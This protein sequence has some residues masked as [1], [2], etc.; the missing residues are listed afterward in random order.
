M[1]TE[2]LVADL[3]SQSIIALDCEGVRLGRYGKLSLMQIALGED[4]NT[5]VLVDGIHGPTIKAL[6]PILG[7]KTVV[8]VMH[9][10]R[11]DSA[12]LFS[13]F[14][15]RLHSVADTQIANL[16]L[17]RESRRVLR[18]EAYSDLLSRYLGRS[19]SLSTDM[20][21]RMLDDPF[22]WHR[23]PLTKELVDYALHG[24]V[25]LIPLLQ[26]MEADLNAGGLSLKHV[27][28]ASQRWIEYSQLNLEIG[29]N[30]SQVEKIG[31]PLLGM[32]AAINDKGVY[33]KLNLARVG[34]CCTPSAM[35]RM[36]KGSGGF[37]PVQV[38]DTVELSVSGVS[39]D[40]KVLYV[41][42]RDP[43]WEYFD[44][45]RRPNPKKVGTAS[46]EYRHV[47]SIIN[48]G[49]VDPLIRRG[50][51]PDGGIDSDDEDQV[52]HNPILTHKPCKPSKHSS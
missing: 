4:P 43:D 6:E 15:I 23:R 26:R 20:K 46:Q 42:R 35:K 27:I 7:S 52:D 3:A 39:L 24:V 49:D 47:T 50:L 29:N 28:S 36:L 5:L 12:A 25:D 41:D 8:K 37:P 16:L 51:G 2:K 19:E 1:D 31:T 38:G 17:Q 22:L 40:G 21:Q 14:G 11:E 18:Q 32:V 48:S 10:C 9:D 34:V 44:Y 13:Q 30:P 45:L 33:F